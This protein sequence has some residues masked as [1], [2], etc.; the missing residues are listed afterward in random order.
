M[1]QAVPFGYI[2]PL[3]LYFV[4]VLCI[5]R[6]RERLALHDM[7]RKNA[8]E[9]AYSFRCGKMPRKKKNIK[10][11]TCHFNVLSNYLQLGLCFLTDCLSSVFLS[12]CRLKTSI[13]P[14]VYVT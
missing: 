5:I 9:A 10:V 14:T 12:L 7:V 8:I 11:S 6:E 4:L 13:K 2:C 1:P 3:E